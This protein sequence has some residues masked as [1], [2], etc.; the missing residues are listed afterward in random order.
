[1]D[2]P[3]TLRHATADD[4]D[5]LRLLKH[6]L[7]LNEHR[8]SKAALDPHADEIDLSFEA[9][10]G[11]VARDLAA[12]AEGRGGIILAEQDARPVGYVAFVVKEG[13]TSIKAEMRNA[14]YIAGIVVDQALRGSGIGALLLAAAEDEARTR[15][16][17][18]MTLDVSTTSPAERL[19]ARS[20]FEPIS[21]TMIKRLA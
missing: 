2:K 1:M 18:R 17:N 13:S 11:T 6:Q 8:W 21:K 19:Y 9:V 5:A 4:A 10:E 3:T 15:G 14:L 20:G 12:M 16:L 7:N